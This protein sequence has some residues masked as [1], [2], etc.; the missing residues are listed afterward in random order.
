M[1]TPSTFSKYGFWKEWTETPCVF[2]KYKPRK[3]G[4]GFQAYQRV[5]AKMVLVHRVVWE[6]AYGSIPKGMKVCHHCD[7]GHCVNLEHLFLGPQIVNVRDMIAKGRNSIRKGEGNGKHKLT[8]DSVDWI[9][10]YAFQLGWSVSLLAE[11]YGVARS[12][13]DSVLSGQ[14]WRDGD[15]F[16][17]RHGLRRGEDHQN[18]LLSNHQR[19]A[20]RLAAILGC[21]QQFLARRYGVSI[22]T[23]S[24]IKCSG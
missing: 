17:Y 5:G 4:N 23:V 16:L 14:T 18:S 24:A 12:T 3:N 22:Q 21:R 10:V 8:R 2:T 1:D 9:R 7:V 19:K 13:M 15:K 11:C 20:I 6:G